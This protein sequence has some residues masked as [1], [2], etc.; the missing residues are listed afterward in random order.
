[1]NCA[2]SAQDKPKDKGAAIRH[3][4]DEGTEREGGRG[5]HCAKGSTDTRQL[6][7]SCKSKAQ[8]VNFSI[9]FMRRGTTGLASLPLV[10]LKLR[11]LRL[12]RLSP[13]DLFMA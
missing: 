10:P 2:Q 4:H 1:M 3:L 13:V 7:V 8:L 12:L 6:L 11:P 9:I 5:G